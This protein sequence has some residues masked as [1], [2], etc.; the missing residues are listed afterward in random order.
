[1]NKIL[2]V[3]LGSCW[4][5][6]A[7]ANPLALDD[8]PEPLQPWTEWALWGTTE[9][10]CPLVQTGVSNAERLCA[11]PSYLQVT[12]SATQAH[13]SQEWQLY[14]SEWI[15]LPGHSQSTHHHWPQ[16]VQVNQ[17]N[18]LVVEREGLPWIRLD[19]GRHQV[20]GVFFWDRVPEF[21]RVPSHTGL[22]TLS[23]MGQEMALP[24]LDRQGRLWLNRNERARETTDEDRLTL[25]V[26]RRLSDQ[27][28]L[29]SVNRL[30]LEVAGR[31]R[32][33]VLAP[34]LLADQIPMQLNSP[35]PA[36]LEP[37]GELRL[38]VRPG[39]W[40][41]EVAARSPHEVTTLHSVAL[42]RDPANHT[43][44]I[45]A[46]EELWSFEAQPML[47]VVEISGVT[48]VD[49]QQTQLPDTWRS[50]PTYRVLP[51]ETMTLSIKQRGLADTTANQLNLYR[52][53][54]LDFDGKGY[55]IQDHITGQ[56]NRH[57]RLNLLNSQNNQD[58]AYAM[59]LGRV[60]VAGQDQFI[61][62]LTENQP[63]GVEIR[64]TQ[65]DVT[66]DSRLYGDIQI[67]PVVGWQH[68]AETESFQQF[69]QVG[70]SLHLP[71]GWSLLHL[72]GADQVTQTWLQNWTLLYQFFQSRIIILFK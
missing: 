8:V 68:E 6:I 41:V 17:I 4:S 30:V 62:R 51:G 2:V 16:Q 71:P 45:W 49:P 25:R 40:E 3:L 22:V 61:T 31:H 67:L 39:T 53:Y 64:Q 27:V 13:F 18:A 50:L 29:Q 26:Y 72:H 28:P 23:V 32:E 36:R 7:L 37:T 33:V 52:Q 66:A 55:S 5:L 70:A 46:T 48:A 42:N 19:A 11:W 20:T 44:G 57:W 56:M 59:Q 21:L 10:A 47:R 24:E 63:M 60:S 54:W 69:Q 65:V 35:L 15:P 38:Q 34:V 43:Q 12:A 1:M 14:R 9:Q 58:A